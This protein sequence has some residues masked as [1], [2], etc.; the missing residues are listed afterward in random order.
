MGKDTGVA[1]RCPRNGTDEM[2]GEGEAK[3]RLRRSAGGGLGAFQM[4]QDFSKDFLFGEEG[5]NAEGAP[6]S[7]FK[8]SVR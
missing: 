6:H 1:L 5:D 4:I 3:L 2:T 7:H 8:G